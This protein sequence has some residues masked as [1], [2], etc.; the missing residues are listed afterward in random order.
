MNGPPSSGHVVSTGSARRS[1]GSITIVCT[2]A[3]IA[4]RGIAD[5]ATEASPAKRP[6]LPPS[7][8]GS[9]MSIVAR[10][11]SSI[12]VSDA[13]PSAIAIRRSLPN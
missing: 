12:S 1:G 11:R 2:A 7:D 8:P 13:P 6:S 9:D 5:E 4:W 3:P 10:R